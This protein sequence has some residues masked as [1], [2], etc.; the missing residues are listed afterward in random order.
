MLDFIEASNGDTENNSLNVHQKHIFNIMWLL[1]NQL[2][3]I[4]CM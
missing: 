2:V 4:F 1:T 3:F